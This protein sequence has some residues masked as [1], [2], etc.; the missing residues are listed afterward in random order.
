[1]VGSGGRGGVRRRPVGQS[2]VEV[3]DDVA[4]STLDV[5]FGDDDSVDE[6]DEEV[7]A[8]ESD[9]D[10]SESEVDDGEPS[11]GAVGEAPLEE[12]ASLR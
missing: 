7:V 5:C 11:E 2:A 9:F 8:G 10:E 12:R 1:M 6:P 4:L 3:D